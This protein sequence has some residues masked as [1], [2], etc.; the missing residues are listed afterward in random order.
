MRGVLSK[1]AL[2]EADAGFV[3]MTDAKT[4]SAHLKEI[5]VPPRA[6][7]KVEYGICV[8]SGSSHKAAARAFVQH[9]LSKAGQRTLHR[10]GFLPR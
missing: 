9:V 2:G 3:Y 1:V 8:V 5:E 7:P 4:A 10:Y 6:A